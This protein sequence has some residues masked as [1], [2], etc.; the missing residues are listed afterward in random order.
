MVSHGAAIRVFTAL[1]G[2]VDSATGETRPLYNT[3]MA[4]LE[5]HPDT[6]FTLRDW[7]TAPIGGS[8]LLGETEHDITADQSEDAP[9]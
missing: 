5:G 3:G 4:T 2:G 1:A 9:A 7:S 8:H 6:G